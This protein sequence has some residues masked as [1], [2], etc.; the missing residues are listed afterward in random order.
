MPT[1]AKL[2]A[3]IVFAAL[4]FMAAELFKP[5]MPEGTQFGLFSPICAGIGLLCGWIVMGP[6]AGRGTWAA[7]GSGVRTAATIAFWALLGFS[8]Y[9]MVLRSMKLRY[10]G[11]MEAVLAVFDLMLERGRLMLMPDL[12]GL[13]LLGG[14]LGGVLVEWAGRR[15]R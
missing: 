3:A 1:A 9:E 10:D 8:I 15:W 13:L 4:G 7:M 14:L 6:L 5:A 11:P 12:L 2:V